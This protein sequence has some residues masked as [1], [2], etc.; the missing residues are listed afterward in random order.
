MSPRDSNCFQMDTNHSKQAN[1]PNS[2]GSS[3]T[4]IQ[5]NQEINS[6]RFDL[7]PSDF[8][9]TGILENPE[10]RDPKKEIP[11]TNFDDLISNFYLLNDNEKA[12]KCTNN[13]N[14]LQQSSNIVK[15]KTD[16]FIP[17]NVTEEKSS[18]HQKSVSKTVS[19]DALLNLRPKS[20]VSIIQPAS[21]KAMPPGL[22]KSEEHHQSIGNPVLTKV[23][24]VI[25]TTQLNVNSGLL[26]NQ[27]KPPI[28]STRKIV[29]PNNFREALPEMSVKETFAISMPQSISNDKNSVRT[30]I[31]PE[32]Q[33]VTSHRK[34]IYK[35]DSS[36]ALN[37]N[38]NIFKYAYS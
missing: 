21:V 30:S 32:G 13:E 8:I 24:S 35:V 1:F 10:E 2:S 27:L 23:S 11:K 20:I 9:S 12:F 17:N 7:S 5:T 15:A 33:S 37:T 6:S 3:L 36:D 26:T 16:E 19:L 28:I 14:N 22:S 18:T 38:R 31:A 34:V 4:T 25:R 29:V